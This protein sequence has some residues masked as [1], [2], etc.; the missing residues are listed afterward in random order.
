[1]T[2][3][4]LSTHMNDRCVAI[5]E[6]G[7]ELRVCTPP[8]SVGKGLE[9]I[10]TINA[11]G[12]GPPLHRHSETEVFYVLQGRYLFEVD[13]ERFEAKMGD[14]VVANGGVPHRFVNIDSC[15]SK[16]LVMIVPGFDAF[17]FFTQLGLAMKNGRLENDAKLA[18]ST[19]WGVDFLG[20][21]LQASST[22]TAASEA[23]RC[24]SPG[25]R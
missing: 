13:G 15:P 3:N 8:S 6:I 19:Q 2:D 10:E 5:P 20:P 9:L 12:Y 1:M 4:S 17:A 22:M 23:D 11:P 21:P 7:L 18:F 16:Q 24:V 25:A 14:T